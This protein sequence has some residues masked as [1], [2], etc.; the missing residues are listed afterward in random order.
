M[1]KTILP[2]QVNMLHNLSEG[3][4]LS[5]DTDCA[6]IECSA[7][8]IRVIGLLILN[9]VDF[10]TTKIDRGFMDTLHWAHNLC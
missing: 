1:A 7:S 4:V 6:H 5:R 2:M 9:S 10:N 3:F 8:V